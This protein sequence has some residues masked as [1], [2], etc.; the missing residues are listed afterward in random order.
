MELFGFLFVNHL[1]YA[2]EELCPSAQSKEKVA[3]MLQALIWDMDA[4]E[5]WKREGIEKASHEVAAI[6]DVHHK[7]VVI[8]ILYI[9]ITG[10]RHGPPLFDGVELL[11]KDRTRARLLHAI[12]LLGSISNKK[13]DLLTKGWAL[14]N[15]KD[16]G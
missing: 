14:R 1:Q 10:K 16:L 13:M 5:N 15:C 6:F 2:P 7:K 9:S 11:G 4:R 3:M 12:E 8:P